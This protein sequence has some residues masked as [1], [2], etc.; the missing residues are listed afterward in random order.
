MIVYRTC[1]TK[2][3]SNFVKNKLLKEMNDQKV[4]DNGQIIHIGII[5]HICFNNVIKEQVELD[6]DYTINMINKDYNKQSS[7]FDIGKNSYKNPTLKQIYD[8][9]VS[10]ATGGNINFYKV[11]IKYSPLE[12]Q[13]SSNISVLDNLIKGRSQPIDPSRYLNVWVVDLSNG[14]LGYAQFPWE[15]NSSLSTDGVIIAKGTF[16]RNPFYSQYNLNKTLTHEVGHWLGLYHT[17]QETYNYEGGNI[18]YI[19]GTPQQEIEEKK[20]DL[21]ADTPPQKDPTYGNPLNNPN[22]WPMSQPIDESKPYYHMYMN[23]MDYSDDEALFMF[24]KDQATKIR[25]LIN[26]YRP[27][28]LTNNPTIIPPVPQ[29]IPIPVPPPIPTPVPTDFFIRYGFE[30]NDGKG[31]ING[32]KILNNSNGTNAQISTLYPFKGTRSFR[33]KKNGICE[34]QS[35]LSGLESAQLSFYAKVLNSYSYVWV[36]PPSSN[37]WY[38]FKLT[39]NIN[40]KLYVLNLPGFF[41]SLNDQHY[42][43]RFGTDG[44][45][46][47]YS[48][49]DEI[50]ISSKIIYSPLKFKKIGNLSNKIKKYT[51]KLFF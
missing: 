11:L 13:T 38:K 37:N 29:P 18:D 46:N 16:G 23:Y 47:N 39:L 9:Y 4:Q 24:T 30:N 2:N 28:I 12:N 43:F 7:N 21:V 8:D 48:Y 25:L 6:A 35:N 40:Y 34:L 41:N 27:N 32:L 19:Q 14:L 10:K 3:D 50:S 20:G 17:F 44:L 26:I 42:K 33:A 51:G 36:K 5:F 31:W 49:F 22:T 15:L 45:S 1:G